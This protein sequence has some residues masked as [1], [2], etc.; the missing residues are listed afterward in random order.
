MRRRSMKAL[1][2]WVILLVMPTRISLPAKAIPS[3]GYA[4]TFERTDVREALGWLA[5]NVAEINDM[6]KR[7]SEIPAPP[8]QEQK[9]AE[10][11]KTLLDSAGLPVRIDKAGNVIGTLA[12]SSDKDGD[13]V[14]LSAHLDTVFPA[15]TNVNAEMDG[16]RQHRPGISG[17]GTG[18]A[19]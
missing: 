11:L 1:T 16:V 9:R 14:V 7:I 15:G 6:Q 5:K 10:A 17:G 2:V 3:D 12:G 18:L 8:F 13:I 19:A 4:A